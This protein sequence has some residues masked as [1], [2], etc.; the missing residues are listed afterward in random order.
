MKKVFKNIRFSVGVP[1]LAAAAFFLAGDMRINYICAL[2]FSCFHEFGHLLAMFCFGKKPTAITFG[3]MGIKIEKNESE[4]SYRQECITALCG[5]FV[6][7]IF[8][9][10]F[11][12]YDI[13]SI[14]FAINAGLFLI[15]ILPVKTLDGGRFVYY[16]CMMKFDEIKVIKILLFFEMLTVIF[17]VAVLFLSLVTGFVNTSFVMF[18]VLLVIMICF[19]LF[20]YNS[21]VG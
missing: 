11:S 7:L 13:K 9:V 3:L 17:L 15:N 19:E 16:L 6:N 14:S 4:L 20:Y 5:P 18:S 10:V 2:L 12:F 1:F 21:T 8:A